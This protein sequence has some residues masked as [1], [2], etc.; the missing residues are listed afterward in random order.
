M[1][2]V[3]I[4]AGA[5]GITAAKTI[6][7]LD[8]SCEILVVSKEEQVHSR[9]MLHKYLSGERTGE[10][11]N[12]VPEDFFE[13]NR[14][15]RIT[16]NGVTGVSCDKRRVRLEDGEELEYDNLLIATGAYYLVPPIPGFKE[17]PNV[18]GFRD[19]CDAE[20]IA[21]M[22]KAGSRAV[23]VGSGLVG[24]DA[25]YALT[26]RGIS[27]VIVEMADRILP[28]QLDASGASA[29]QTLF[30]AHG[31]RFRLSAKAADTRR[32]ES[33]AVTAVILGD[34]E[35]LECDFVVVA[36]GVRPEVRFLEGCGVETERAIRVN[37]YLETTVPHI[38]AAGDVAGLSAI[39]P[40]AMKQ[41]VTAAR[42][43]CGLPTRYEDTYAM[44]NTMNFFG[45][46]SL[47]IGDI[48]RIGE[49]TEVVTAED[50]KNYKKAL[51]ED[52]KLKSILLQGDIGGSGIYQYLIKNE[53]PL[54][55]EGRELFKLSFAN[56]YGFDPANGKYQ[57][58]G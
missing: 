29:Y 47:C 33:G 49:K 4:G 28:L 5:A 26:E 6:R 14:I 39:W 42:N 35:E 32:D 46:A 45:L 20:A 58:V 12:F 38:Y 27:P 37:E 11:I 21:A 9:C 23:I 3:I 13:K 56:F 34:G 16:G 10:E 50:R 51:V 43:M 53:I 44:K 52:G 48:N 40:N 1:R 7:E 18:F 36:A 55:V 17:A 57:F 2:Q 31:C 22:A 19:L 54:P 41:G 25:A 24:M 15:G 8:G 30:E